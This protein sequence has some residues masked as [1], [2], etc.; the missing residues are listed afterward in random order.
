[1]QD[2]SGHSAKPFPRR[3]ENHKNPLRAL[4]LCGETP[5][6]DSQLNTERGQKVLAASKMPGGCPAGLLSKKHDAAEGF[7]VLAA[8]VLP[9]LV[10]PAANHLLHL[11]PL[12]GRR[13]G[14][15]H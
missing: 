2:Y 1:M 11:R 9:V 15:L 4:R 10:G 7:R 14:V 5:V 3:K 6:A 13:A 8:V 12:P